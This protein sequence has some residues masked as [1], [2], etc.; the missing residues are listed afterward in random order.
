MGRKSSFPSTGYVSRLK[1]H[2]IDLR[3]CHQ[4]FVHTP[5][6]GN[7]T[8]LGPSG[9][10]NILAKVPVDAGYGGAIHFYMSGAEHEAIECGVNS[11]TVI[12]VVIKDVDGNEID[13]KGGHWSMALIF[14]H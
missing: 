10:W 2:F 3:R 1:S 7:Y 8:T 11:L 14:D 12:K 4:L 9:E 5:G 6:F 13:P